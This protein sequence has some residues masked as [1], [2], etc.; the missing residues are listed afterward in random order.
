MA[1]HRTDLPAAGGGR[2]AGN[3]PVSGE[4]DMQYG[5]SD[6]DAE[7][8]LD[9]AADAGA[10]CGHDLEDH[11]QSEF[12]DHCH[13]NCGA[14]AVCVL[15]RLQ[16]VYPAGAGWACRSCGRSISDRTA[17]GFTGRQ[18]EFPWRACAGMAGSG[19][20]RER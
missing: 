19:G 20:V 18:S 15:P 11:Q 5:K 17:G 4:Y 9:D 2:E 10:A 1:V 14:D 16:T 13:G 6:T 7:G 12:G 8:L 3:D